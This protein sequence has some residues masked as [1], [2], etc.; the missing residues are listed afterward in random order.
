MIRPTFYTITQFL[1]R[2]IWMAGHPLVFLLMMLFSV[3]G[4]YATAYIFSINNFLEFYGS[5][6]MF[7]QMASY[8]TIVGL[9]YKIFHHLFTGN[10]KMFTLH[11]FEGNAYYMDKR[12]N[13]WIA[14]YLIVQWGVLILYEFVHVPNNFWEFLPA[15]VFFV[16][17]L[18]LF[19][20]VWSMG[21]PERAGMV[22]QPEATYIAFLWQVGIS[23]FL[24]LGTHLFLLFRLFGPP[25]SFIP[26]GGDWVTQMVTLGLVA[27]ILTIVGAYGIWGYGNAKHQ[28]KE[29]DIEE[30]KRERG[31]SNI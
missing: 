3:T 7:M 12:Y 1:L 27:T 17:D 19:F 16:S 29:K 23:A 8:T 14:V 26:V 31:Y 5:Y 4:L 6:L 24:N 9:G 25:F 20:L 10:R 13:V 28:M 22:N 2:S 30:S 18:L 15:T 11:A 21:P